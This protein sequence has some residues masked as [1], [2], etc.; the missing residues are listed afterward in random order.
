[1]GHPHA[2]KRVI[3]WNETA[4]GWY[5]VETD[6]SVKNLT[7]ADVP[8]DQSFIGDLW[9]PPRVEVAGETDDPVVQQITS[10]VRYEIDRRTV[11]STRMYFNSDP[12]DDRFVTVAYHKMALREANDEARDR[13]IQLENRII[14]LHQRITALEKPWWKRW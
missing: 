3:Y 13:H 9:G 12:K 2:I 14:A 11:Y 8:N 6:V 10:I 1:M 7:I 5:D 4:G